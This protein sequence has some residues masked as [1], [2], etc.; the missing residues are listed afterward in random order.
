ML[1][2]KA[3]L[4]CS[5]KSSSTA[6][7]TAAPVPVH[8]LTYVNMNAPG[9][10]AKRASPDHEYKMALGRYAISRRSRYDCADRHQ[11]TAIFIL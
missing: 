7:G 10:R 3:E 6:H 5:A 11:N 4:S 8:P 2:E 9:V 1:R